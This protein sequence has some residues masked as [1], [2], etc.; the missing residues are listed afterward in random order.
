MYY[1]LKFFLSFN[2]PLHISVD[3]ICLFVF[4]FLVVQWSCCVL[5]DQESPPTL[6]DH[7]SVGEQLCVC[8]Q[9]GQPQPALQHEWI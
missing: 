3:F 6:S 8:L 9:Q 5:G 1:K 4:V 7:H 2:I